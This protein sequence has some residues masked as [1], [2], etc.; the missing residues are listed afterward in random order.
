MTASCDPYAT[1]TLVIANGGFESGEV[2]PWVPTITSAPG[3]IIGAVSNDR[4]H[5]GSNTYNIGF[6]NLDG[7]FLR[8]MQTIKIEP[9]KNCEMSY[10]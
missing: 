1:P 8:L 7:G 10:W 9:G 3:N 6:K 5:S 2:G 4:S